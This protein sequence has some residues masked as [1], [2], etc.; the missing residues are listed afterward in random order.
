MPPQKQKNAGQHLMDRRTALLA[1]SVLVPASLLS[2][3][4]EAVPATEPEP[5]QSQPRYR[6]TDHIRAFYER[7]RF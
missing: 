5:D 1:P 3:A 6:E 4:A 7:S 2:A